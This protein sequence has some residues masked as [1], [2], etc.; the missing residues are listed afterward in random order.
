MLVLVTIVTLILGIA[1]GSVNISPMAFFTD[2][3]MRVIILNV[4]LP[5]VLMAFVAG[6]GLSL[7]GVIVQAVLKNPLA[8]S[9]TLGTASGASVGAS[10]AIIASLS[11]LGAFTIPF[12]GFLFAT[13]TV[14]ICIYIAN[15]VNGLKNISIILFGMAISFFF[16]SI[17][18]IMLVFNA[19]SPQRLIFWQL[20]SFF[21]FSYTHIIIINVVVL[22]CSILTI[23]KN[24]ALD[25][26]TLDDV[27][28]K[29]I[30]IDTPK[31]KAFFLLTSAVLTGSII[32]FTGIIG[33]VDLFSPHIARKI[34]GASHR[35]I[36]IPACLIGGNFMVLSD[37][38]SRT[39]F[40]PREIPVGAVTAFIGGPLFIYIFATMRKN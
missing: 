2:E 33:F 28:A 21:G 23:V 16:N 17:L 12:F 30:G 8:G 20:G 38:I 35:K 3:T 26:L 5:R 11:F 31:Y 4:R 22:L 14:F 39:I 13:L 19:E 27:A 24:K 18:T 9:F 10:L 34:Y 36:I 6:F 32:S 40:S 29:S 7:S 25:I 1:I 37:L 15:K